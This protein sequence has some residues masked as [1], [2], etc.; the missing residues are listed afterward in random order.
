MKTISKFLFFAFLLFFNSAFADLA[1]DAEKL[2]SWGEQKYPSYFSIG[3]T[4]VVTKVLNYKEHDWY[5]RYYPET[6]VFLAINELNKVYVLGGVF[7]RNL[8]YI[9]RLEDLL[10]VPS[11][12]SSAQLKGKLS[13]ANVKIYRVEDNSDKTL[14]YQEKTDSNGDFYA[15]EDKLDD[16]KFYIYEVSGGIDNKGTIRAVTKG[17]WIKKQGLKVSLASEMAY[18]YL[19]KDLKY[20]FDATKVENRLN[21]VAQ[22]IFK[23]DISGDGKVTNA[24]LLVFDYQNDFN[25]IN[26]SKFSDSKIEEIV[27]SIYRGNLSYADD[28]STYTIGNYNS[29]YAFGITLSQDG[30]KAFIAGGGRSAGGGKD[31]GLVILDISNPANPIKIGNYDT[32]GNAMKITLSRDETK[33]YIADDSN[34]LVITDISDLTNPIKIGHYDTNGF[35]RGIALSQD[36]TKAFV[37]DDYNGLVI[38]DIKDPKNPVKIGSFSTLGKGNVTKIVLS[39]D[40]TKAYLADYANG[41]L[42][43]DITNPTKPIKIGSLDTKTN[44]FGGAWDITLSADGTTAFVAKGDPMMNDGGLVI[45]DIRNPVNPIKVGEFNTNRNARGVSLSKDETKAFLANEE[46]S[47]VVL[48]ITDSKNPIKIRGFDIGWTNKVNLSSDDTKVFAATSTGLSILDLKLFNPISDK[49]PAQ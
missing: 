1:S 13:N 33:A 48:D 6:K 16:D 17:N 47:L 4:E 32:D 2:F 18:I 49:A 3:E 31:E 25:A 26:K 27:L 24:D 7:G 30:T 19:A 38:I 43:F 36:G 10:D 35:A 21:E 41:L 28:I 46:N 20:D 11:L 44:G 40:G 23:I 34:G 29:G 42:V 15:H 45:A 22:T 9:G 39:N 8:L 12:A 14:L 5:Y 37:A